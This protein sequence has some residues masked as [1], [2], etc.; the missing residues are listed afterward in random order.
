MS[1]IVTIRFYEG[2]YCVKGAEDAKN[3]KG[4]RH[5]KL[6]F[7]VPTTSESKTF[8]EVQLQNVV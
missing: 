6:S 1:Q 2:T 3:V 8:K 5:S 7:S 4:K